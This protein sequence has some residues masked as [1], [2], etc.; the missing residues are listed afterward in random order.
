MI[1]SLICFGILA[2]VGPALL[3]FLLVNQVLTWLITNKTVLGWVRL[4]FFFG[5]M[6]LIMPITRLLD[7][8]GWYWLLF[9][10]LG[11]AGMAWQM[12]LIGEALVTGAIDAVK[13]I[14]ATRR[15]EV[16][17][18]VVAQHLRDGDYRCA[19][20]PTNHTPRR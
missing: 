6:A 9:V 1:A 2:T 19:R 13:D 17:A 12:G 5:C 8:T 7:Q 11:I 4:P 20:F 15:A 16:M 14:S 3:A 10:L 18:P